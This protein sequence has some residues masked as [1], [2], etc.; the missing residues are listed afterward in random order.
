MPNAQVIY[1]VLCFLALG[2]LQH[3]IKFDS[4]TM[5]MMEKLLGTGSFG[6]MTGH[7]ACC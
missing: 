4:C 3:D 1:C 5:A 7:L 6:I 2:I